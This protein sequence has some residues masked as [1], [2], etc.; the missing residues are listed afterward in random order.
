MN[1]KTILIFLSILF[2]N[3]FYAFTQ[4]SD[5]STPSDYRPYFEEAYELNDNLPLGILE[6][7]SY[8]LT[9]IYHHI[10]KTKDGSCT[11]MPHS[12]G[13]MGLYLDGKGNFTNTVQLVSEISGYTTDQIIN[14]PRYNILATAKYLSEL[15][16]S[17]QINSKNL[18]E[19]KPLISQAAGL[20]D[21]NE[22]DKYVNDMISWQ[23]FETLKTGVNLNGVRYLKENPALNVDA[24]F[25]E[26]NLKLFKAPKIKINTLKSS[27]SADYGPA[28]WNPA[29]TC[30]YGNGRS[31]AISDVVCHI[32]DGF[33]AGSISWFQNCT[34][35]VSAHYCVRSMDGQITQMV[36]ESNTGYHVSGHNSYTIGIEHE[37]FDSNASDWLTTV[38]YTES[39]ALTAD[40]CSSHG[41]NPLDAYNGTSQAELW[42]S[43]YKI[44]GHTH[45]P[46]TKT[47]PSTSWNYALYYDLV[48]GTACPPNQT[49]TTYSTGTI[50]A[51][52]YI[53]SSG[54]VVAGNS[55]VYDAGNYIELTTGFDGQSG[56]V[57]EGKIEGCPN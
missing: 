39:A 40:I 45:Y 53:T 20:P 9:R 8:N 50:V 24:L 33:Y 49:I 25:E 38:M 57:F 41:I 28:L 1:H 54:G 2:L 27:S 7:I 30:N 44:L 10:P 13:V 18:A 29:A 47:C 31:S 22:V 3:G 52:N 11:G 34:S 21:N 42:N 6:A 23:V 35:G 36:L 55:A 48:N 32:M 14:S 43:S 5:P 19:W 12:I 37:G 46:T 17:K 4:K 16:K 15:A 26:E 56:S 51:G